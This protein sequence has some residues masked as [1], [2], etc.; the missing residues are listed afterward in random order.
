MSGRVLVIGAGLAGLSAAR[1]LGAGAVVL[2]G[3]GEVGG[4]C[5]SYRRDGYTFP[6][7]VLSAGDWR[8]LRRARAASC[9]RRSAISRTF[10]SSGWTT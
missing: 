3:A 6:V 7:P 5:R 1:H 4:L 9:S 10:C 8:P 2:E